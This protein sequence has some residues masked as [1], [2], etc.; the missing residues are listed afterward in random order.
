M[1][2]ATRR[3]KRREMIHT[4]EPWRKHGPADNLDFELLASIT[5][6]K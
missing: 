3:W 1:S 6:T 5:K 2:G 4:Q